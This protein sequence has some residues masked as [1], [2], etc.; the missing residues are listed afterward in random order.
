VGGEQYPQDTSAAARPAAEA[1]RRARCTTEDALPRPS[2]IHGDESQL[3]PAPNY[4]APQYPRLRE[5]AGKVAPIMGGT[6]G[7]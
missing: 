5:L 2:E 3:R 6:P 7:G 1:D 4:E